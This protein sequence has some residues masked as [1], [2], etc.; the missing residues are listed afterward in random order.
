VSRGKLHT[1]NLYSPVHGRN[2][3]SHFMTAWSAI[4]PLILFGMAGAAPAGE[5]CGLHTAENAYPV[6]V[7]VRRE[8]LADISVSSPVIKHVTCEAERFVLTS[9]G[10]DDTQTLVWAASSEDTA[11]CVPQAEL[12]L[13]YTS[14]INEMTMTMKTAGRQPY[15]VRLTQEAC[16][17]AHPSLVRGRGTRKLAEPSEGG[18]SQSIF[19]QRLPTLHIDPKSVITSGCSHAGDFASQFHIAFSKMVSGACVFSGQPF[20]CAVHKFSRDYLVPQTPA[21]G[22]P[23]CD[24]CPNNGENWT[25]MYDHCKNHPQFMDVGE[26][27]DYPRRAC[28]QNPITETPCIDD[29]K[30]LFDARAYVFRPTA[31]RC[32]QYGSVETTAALYGMLMKNP[33]ETMKL[34]NDQPFP[35]TLPTNS[36]PYFNSS[37]PAGFDGPGECLR[38]VYGERFGYSPLK[39]AIDAIPRNMFTFNQTEFWDADTFG[40]GIRATGEIYIPTQCQVDSPTFETEPC[41][42]LFTLGVDDDFARYGEANGIVIVALGIGGYVD[43]DRFPNACEVQR[44]L[45]DVY[46]QLGPDYTWQNGYQMRVG[47]RILRRL[48]GLPE[49]EPWHD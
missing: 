32:Y 15:D 41:K 25:L 1:N 2:L 45:S 38:W 16:H 26:L 30:Y 8:S 6:R 33:V 23:Y 9:Q 27:V 4:A 7:N 43:T 44:G 24:G 13:T 12:V 47:G 31:D 20:H 48:L 3:H 18:Q 21:S 5:Y 37:E 40:T 14:S 42:L 10:D 36:T 46:G 28:G 35:H 17:S 22:V 29:V 34:V 39:Y 11:R 19:L 49:N